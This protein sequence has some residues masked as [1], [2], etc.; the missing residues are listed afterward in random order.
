MSETITNELMVERDGRVAL[1]RL[2]RPA[3]LNAVTPRMW[4]A[5]A[6]A[7]DEL[8]NDRDV[9]AVLLCA[10]GR[11]FCAGADISGPPDGY[12]APEGPADVRSEMRALSAIVLRLANFDRPVVAAVKGPVVGI[13]WTLALACDAIIA[14]DDARFCAIYLDR[15]LVPECGT[16]P[17]LARQIGQFR[18]REIV[19]SRRFVEAREALSLGLVNEVVPTADLDETALALAKRLADMPGFATALTKQLFNRLSAL[20]D[21]VAAELLATPA[22]FS[23]V[24]RT[25][26]MLALREGRPPRFTGR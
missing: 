25:E 14:G 15:A 16:I 11:G 21:Q 24:D 9:G 2:N 12:P 26:A 1:L 7:L 10:S 23:A 22:A 5:F 17:L 8:E 13:G 19:Y 20:E 3:K 18:A 4:S 6:D